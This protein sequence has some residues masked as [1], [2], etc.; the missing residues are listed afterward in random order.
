MLADQVELTPNKRLTPLSRGIDALQAPAAAMHKT[1]IFKRLFQS[2]VA[3]ER[4]PPPFGCYL[5]AGS[6]RKWG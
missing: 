5:A 2:I 1:L 3:I 4:A 6:N